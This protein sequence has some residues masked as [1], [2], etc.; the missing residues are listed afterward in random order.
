MPADYVAHPPKHDSAIG[1]GH[2]VYTDRPI[3]QN[4]SSL[5]F[6]PVQL[7][8]T[9]PIPSHPIMAPMTTLEVPH[10]SGIPCERP[11]EIVPQNAW[12]VVPVACQQPILDIAASN[13]KVGK[14]GA[15]K[16]PEERE[17]TAFT[18]KIGSCLRCKSQRIRVSPVSP[19]A[20]PSIVE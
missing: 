14:R 13:S 9:T 8:L 19:S 12:S 7:D 1:N 20:N 6:G 4:P 11:A 16:T 3:P 10:Y 18:R 5:S 2:I 15:F 17:Q